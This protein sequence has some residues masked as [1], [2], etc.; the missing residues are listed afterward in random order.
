MTYEAPAPYETETSQ[1]R[2]RTH[3]G[4]LDLSKVTVHPT[5]GMEDPWN[6][7]NKAQVP[8]G[9]AVTQIAGFYQ[10]R[11]HDT[12]RHERSPDPAIQKRRSQFQA[13]KDICANFTVSK[14]T[15]TKNATKAGSATHHG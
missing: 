15:T 3:P 12:S 11:S 7:R 1:R 2:L 10:Q 9:S 14:F 6:Y 5:L 4:K 13:V 8:V